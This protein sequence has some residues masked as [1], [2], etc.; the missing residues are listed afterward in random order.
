MYKI[1]ITGQNGFIGTHLYNTLA[2]YPDR[3]KRIEFHKKF[4][5]LERSLDEFVSQCD[6]IV[7]L[8]AVNRHDREDVIY[9]TNMRLVDKL[10]ASLNR[11]RSR[12][13]IIFSSSS[14]EERDNSYGRS[15]KAGRERLV[16]WAKRLVGK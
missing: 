4:F 6:T 10:I 13:H 9:D 5:E 1:G 15:K 16:Q 7:H 14:Q 2:L 3:Y 8:A 12:A 11:T